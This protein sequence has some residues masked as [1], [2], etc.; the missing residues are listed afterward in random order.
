VNVTVERSPAVNPDAS[1]VAAGPGPSSEQA[2][3]PRVVM[4]TTTNRL[5]VVV[6]GV[7]TD[8]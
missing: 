4:M 1:A 8:R 5:T 6:T 2:A 3:S 7:I